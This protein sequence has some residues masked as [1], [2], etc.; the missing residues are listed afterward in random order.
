VAVTQPWSALIAVAVGLI[1]VWMALLIAL[2]VIRPKD[3]SVT[4]ALR[5]LPDTVV[6]L[7]RL[8]ADPQLARGVRVRLL[9][10]L[11]YLIL[12][13]DLVPDFIPVLGYAD[14]AIIVAAALRSVVRRAGPGALDKHWPG[15]P[16][17][18]HAVRRLTGIPSPPET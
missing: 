14:D 17:G 3:L 12:P 1:I 5:L 11:A 13:I 4:D 10:L 2:A 18:L 16:E 8:A 9:L 15:T 7:R 6:L